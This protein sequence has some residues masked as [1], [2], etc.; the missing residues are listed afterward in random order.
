MDEL[1]RK[2]GLDPLDS[3][4]K[5][6]ELLYIKLDECENN[7]QNVTDEQ[8]IMELKE[9]YD[10]L[11][12]ALEQLTK[13]KNELA[14]A[15]VSDD[16]N[17]HNP[18]SSRNDRGSSL[19]DVDLAIEQMI[20]QA[21]KKN[22]SK[23]QQ[24]SVEENSTDN[25]AESELESQL[26]SQSR[27]AEQ[28]EE[29]EKQRK[30]EA[31]RRRQE[32]ERRKQEAEDQER[33]ARMREEYLKVKK[34]KEAAK[35]EAAKKAAEELEQMQKKAKESSKTANASDTSETSKT[36]NTD[37]VTNSSKKDQSAGTV[38][39]KKQ[40]LSKLK[41]GIEDFAEED[42]LK[43]LIQAE[44]EKSN[45]LEARLINANEYRNHVIGICV[46]AISLILGL[47]S[48]RLDLVGIF[49]NIDFKSKLSGF[50]II[51]AFNS[52]R[53]LITDPNYFF[54]HRNL[55]SLLFLF[56]LCCLLW[57]LQIKFLIGKKRLDKLIP[58]YIIYMVAILGYAFYCYKVT[59]R[60]NDFGDYFGFFF[61]H[62]TT[63]LSQITMPH[64][65]I[66]LGV[67][68]IL[69]FFYHLIW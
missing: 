68:M 21:K 6:L 10:L 47:V 63:Y 12:E 32:E 24:Q 27:M 3:I 8:I 22:E 60:L 62:I 23:A 29:E 13:K 25:K 51:A 7:Q 52:L 2:V 26:E 44:R 43:K 42:R 40:T 17:Q 18:T 37:K 28:R 4:E 58:F 19:S 16:S 56:Y 59:G 65:L 55:P 48:V 14:S 33:E 54:R 49:H 38:N 64:G 45:K 50:N 67:T 15:L 30:L 69:M 66:L 9:E 34:Q 57:G 53:F 61:L 31:E 36:E 20:A 35:K 46:F 1:L 5:N 41:K 39:E 11:E